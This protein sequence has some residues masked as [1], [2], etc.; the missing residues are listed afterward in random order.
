MN[1]GVNLTKINGKDGQKLLYIY[2]WWPMKAKRGKAIS[3]DTNDDEKLK[4]STNSMTVANLLAVDIVP[5]RPKTTN[6]G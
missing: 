6:E 4:L 2:I 5:E 1:F 3:E